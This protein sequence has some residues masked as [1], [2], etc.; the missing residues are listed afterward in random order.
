MQKRY[1]TSAF[2][3]NGTSIVMVKH[4]GDIDPEPFWALPGG[5]VEVGETS[6]QAIIREVKE[7]TG[8]TVN[9]LAQVAYT[10]EVHRN[11][12]NELGIA[13]IYDITDWSGDFSINDPDNKVLDVAFIPLEQAIVELTKGSYI[14]M[15]EP[16][17]AYLKGD[18]AVGTVYRYRVTP[19]HEAELME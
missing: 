9:G 19:T 4:Q 5:R 7:E 10:V 11:E 8:L 6:E 16:P 3:R 17:L 13:T 15:Q 12:E 18:A 14:P 1:F 2:V